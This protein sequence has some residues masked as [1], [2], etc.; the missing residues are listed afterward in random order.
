MEIEITRLSSYEVSCKQGRFKYVANLGDQS[1]RCSLYIT[2]EHPCIIAVIHGTYDEEKITDIRI[3]KQGVKFAIVTTS[4][5]EI[6]IH[7]GNIVELNIQI[8]LDTIKTTVKKTASIEIKNGGEQLLQS[9]L[10]HFL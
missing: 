3:I 9:C 10:T 6:V 4:D 5:E 8:I 1:N 7:T 2:K